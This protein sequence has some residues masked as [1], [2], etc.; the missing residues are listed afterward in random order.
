[1]KRNCLACVTAETEKDV[2]RK[3]KNHEFQVVYI[4]PEI[5]LIKRRYVH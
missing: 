5:L 1:M 4:S 3:I 2:I